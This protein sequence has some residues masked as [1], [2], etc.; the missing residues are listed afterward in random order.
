MASPLTRRGLPPAAPAPPAVS[1]FDPGLRTNRVG[2][3]T[4][5]TS[6][7]SGRA[8]GRAVRPDGIFDSANIDS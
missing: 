7:A 8:S 3:T 5:P 1:G 4:A 2:R 6:S